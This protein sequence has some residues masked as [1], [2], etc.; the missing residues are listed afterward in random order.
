MSFNGLKRKKL[1]SV[2]F[3]GF[4]LIKKGLSKLKK[5]KTKREGLVNV[6]EGGL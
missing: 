1:R 2:C 4:Y 5:T 3:E 6:N